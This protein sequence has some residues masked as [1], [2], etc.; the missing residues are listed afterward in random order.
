MRARSV[1]GGTLR[2]LGKAIYELRKP[3]MVVVTVFSWNHCLSTYV[4][5]QTRIS[6]PSMLPTINEDGDIL[7][8]ETRTVR[9]DELKKGNIVI[10][11]SPREPKKFLCKRIIALEGE[12]VEIES[13]WNPALSNRIL[14]PKGHVWI[15]GDNLKNSSDSRS[16]GSV[17]RALII[18]R[19]FARIYPFSQ[20]KWLEDTVEFAYTPAF[21]ELKRKAKIREQKLLER[22]KEL[23]ELKDN[24]EAQFGTVDEYTWEFV[25]GYKYG[26]IEPFEDTMWHSSSPPKD[27]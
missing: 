22:E 23:K 17:P 1:L 14:V 13:V 6:G 9:R 10:L 4:G 15:Q 11:N 16:Y 12:E 20:A 25:K 18:G 5:D 3:T 27:R 8:Y 26:S 21:L 24:L 7:L 19:A 2:R